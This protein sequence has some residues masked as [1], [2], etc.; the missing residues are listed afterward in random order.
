MG[1][2]DSPLAAVILAGRSPEE[3]DP[4]AAYSLGRPKGLIPIAGRPMITYVIEALAG[5]RY[6]EH[7]TIIG[8]P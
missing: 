2:E 4:L 5:S 6:V 1:R 3:A 7:I 8:L